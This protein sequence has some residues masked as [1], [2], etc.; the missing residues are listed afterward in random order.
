MPPQIAASS[1]FPSSRM[2]SIKVKPFVAST[3][4]SVPARSVTKISGIVRSRTSGERALRLSYYR[5]VRGLANGRRVAAPACSVKRPSADRKTTAG[6]Q[7]GDPVHEDAQF[8]A[9]MP[10]RRID[11]VQR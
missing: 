3:A 2:A 7:A 6:E 9:E 1:N 5:G 8:V 10:V 11:D 4:N